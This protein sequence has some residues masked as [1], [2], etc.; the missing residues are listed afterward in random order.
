VIGIENAANAEAARRETEPSF[1]SDGR[2]MDRFVSAD[3]SG[4]SGEEATQRM[5]H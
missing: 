2:G 1:P 5:D 3:R 4:E